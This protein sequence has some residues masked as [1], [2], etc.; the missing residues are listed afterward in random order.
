MDTTA[1]ISYQRLRNDQPA[2]F[3]AAY[4]VYATH[5]QAAPEAKAR[6]L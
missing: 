2:A 4:R 6:S 1:G 5:K 3:E